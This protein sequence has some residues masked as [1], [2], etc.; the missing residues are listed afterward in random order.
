[1]FHPHILDHRFNAGSCVQRYLDASM[2]SW[3]I[4]TSLLH[5]AVLATVVYIHWLKIYEYMTFRA[6]LNI[7]LITSISNITCKRNREAKNNTNVFRLIILLDNLHV[8][9]AYVSTGL[10]N[11][12]IAIFVRFRG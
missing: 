11:T 2:Y 4:S 9:A 6:L 1:M 10:T 5:I 12:N 8:S 7:F 3:T